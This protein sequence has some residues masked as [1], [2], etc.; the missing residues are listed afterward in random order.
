[1]EN[2]RPRVGGTETGTGRKDARRGGES[3]HTDGC[4]YSRVETMS[5]GRE[6]GQKKPLRIDNNG[7]RRAVT[8][9]RRRAWGGVWRHDVPVASIRNTPAVSPKLD[10][11]P[12]MPS[13]LTHQILVESV[14]SGDWYTC[15]RLNSRSFPSSIHGG[16]LVGQ[17][18]GIHE[19]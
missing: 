13:N 3:E 6:A 17:R 12:A 1:M 9:W 11:A 8:R 18:A 7:Q 4:G 19:I 10:A 5:A 15:V 14:G 16:R 2:E